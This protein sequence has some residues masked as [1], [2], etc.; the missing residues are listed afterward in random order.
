MS[1]QELYESGFKKRNRDH[2]AAIVRIAMSDHDI[3]ND[4]K[5]FLN[6]LAQNLDVTEDQY[7]EILKDYGTHEI[8]PPVEYDVRL[9]RLYD[10]TRM[11][12]IDHALVNEHETRLLKRLAIGLGFSVTNVDYVVDK[13]LKLV[14]SKV[15]L[16]SFIEEIKHMYK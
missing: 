15:D 13:A 5:N 8:N 4:E 6:R 1:I 10:L 9:E 12:Y 14:S 16:D 3:S 2:F 7:R 11:V